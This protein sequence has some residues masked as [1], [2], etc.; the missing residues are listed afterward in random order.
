METWIGNNTVIAC[1]SP[2]Q[3]WSYYDPGYVMIYNLSYSSYF[4]PF[5]AHLFQGNCR[6]IEFFGSCRWLFWSRTTIC[7]W[8]RKGLCLGLCVARSVARSWGSRWGGGS[9][10]DK[11][12]FQKLWAPR[13]GIKEGV[14]GFDVNAY[15]VD[16]IGG[17]EDVWFSIFNHRNSHHMRAHRP[18]E[19]YAGNEQ[20]LG[21]A[22]E[23]S[24][25]RSPFLFKSH[26]SFE[27][28]PPSGCSPTRIF[29]HSHPPHQRGIECILKTSMEHHG[30]TKA[31]GE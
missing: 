21:M 13:N 16:L 20:F 12:C 10:V 17:F 14:V 3:L 15:L 30:T 6:I 19:I 18:L 11:W 7:S 5:K 8:W 25:P 22:V 28:C 23:T 24:W 9:M 27:T 4:I 2:E 31:W 26:G 29:T 1:Y